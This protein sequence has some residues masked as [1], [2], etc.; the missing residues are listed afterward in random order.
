MSETFLTELPLVFFTITS[1]KPNVCIL[2]RVKQSVLVTNTWTRD[3][4]PVLTSILML[5]AVK[6]PQISI[7]P[8]RFF[9]SNQ[10]TLLSS[11]WQHYSIQSFYFEQTSFHC[12]SWRLSTTKKDTFY[13][14]LYL[15]AAFW[16]KLPGKHATAVSLLQ[17]SHCYKVHV[18]L[19]KTWQL[20]CTWTHSSIRHTNMHHFVEIIETQ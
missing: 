9:S 1:P 18:P 4:D 13:V 8:T 14:S 3:L 19:I 5:L 16:L 20:K 7:H 12:W 15:A 2:S 6:T 11:Y 17:W 10:P